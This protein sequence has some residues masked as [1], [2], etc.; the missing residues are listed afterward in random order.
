MRQTTD[1]TSTHGLVAR[2]CCAGPD[3]NRAVGL[4]SL[5]SFGLIAVSSG[6]PEFSNCRSDLSMHL[7]EHALGGRIR[8]LGW[9]GRVDR[10]AAGH[11][12]GCRLR[13]WR[14]RGLLLG[15]RFGADLLGITALFARHHRPQDAAVLVLSILSSV[16][17]PTT[18]PGVPACRRIGP[19]R[20]GSAD[21]RIASPA[22]PGC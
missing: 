17:T 15:Q 1:C 3:T 19:R 7:R 4:H 21:R 22:G 18:A 6:K 14:R 8:V 10:K 20:S 11:S 13:R 16:P 12:G 2:G 9:V 5:P